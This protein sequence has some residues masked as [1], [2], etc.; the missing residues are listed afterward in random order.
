MIRRSLLGRAA[1][2]G[3][4]VTAL[5]VGPLTAPGAAAAELGAFSGTSNGFA[6]RV[7]VDASGLLAAAP[8]LGSALEETGAL[9][10]G[11]LDVTLLSTDGQADTDTA[12]AASTFIKGSPLLAELFPGDNHVQASPGNPQN[13]SDP[14]AFSLPGDVAGTD[15][16]IVSGTLQELSAAVT[17]SPSAT[18]LGRLGPVNASLDSV[19]DGLPQEARDALQ[20]AVDELNATLETVRTQVDE[21]RDEAEAAGKP[22]EDAVSELLGPVPTGTTVDDAVDQLLTAVDSTDDLV[23]DVPNPLDLLSNLLTVDA[24]LSDVGVARTASGIEANAASALG[25]VSVLGDIVT[26]D[27]VNLSAVAAA[28]GSPGGATADASCD[29]VNLQ[30]SDLDVLSLSD[31]VLS[32]GGVDLDVNELTQPVRDAVN[33]VLG[34]LSVSV[35]AGELCR[36]TEDAAADGN[37]ASASAELAPISVG[38]GVPE[39]ARSAFGGADTL[40]SIM[41]DPTVQSAVTAHPQI[42]QT[43]EKQAAPTSLPRTGAG[44]FGTVVS[45]LAL[46]GGAFA[47]RRWIR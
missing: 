38:V 25:H 36:V 39:A 2:V 10:N 14:R 37:S 35:D 18:G 45:G 33:Q 6:L 43:E 1:G 16:S 46:T 4:L 23:A 8:A 32:V 29:A 30:V 27:A 41:V 40:A 34:L 21:V 44:I 7:V 9:Q 5:I 17:E 11:T 31:G 12:Q 19:V 26:L 15:F 13:S 20:Q 24:P 22:V 42:T 28:T 3:A 47:I